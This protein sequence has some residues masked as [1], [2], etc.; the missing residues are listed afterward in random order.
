MLQDFRASQENQ[1]VSRG[2]KRKRVHYME[3]EQLDE[4]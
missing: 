2:I 1:A 3:K 4:E